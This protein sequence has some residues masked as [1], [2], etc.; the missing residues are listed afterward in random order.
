MNY[1]I[2]IK[3]VIWK[4]EERH[5]AMAFVDDINLAEDSLNALL[6]RFKN[7]LVLDME[8]VMNIVK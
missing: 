2:K 4:K 1:G 8:S 3:W 6:P 5:L 7:T